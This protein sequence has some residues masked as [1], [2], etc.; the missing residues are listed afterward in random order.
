S[1]APPLAPLTLQEGGP[2]AVGANPQG[3][4][5]GSFYGSAA[6]ALLTANAG[7]TSVS[8]LHGTGGQGFGPPAALAGGVPSVAVGSDRLTNNFSRR[9]LAV[10]SAISNTV[11]VLLSNGDGTFQAPASY[12]VGM[13]PVALVA[14]DLSRDG[15]ADL[16]T[17]NRDSNSVSL[18]IS[19]STGWF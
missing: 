10:A 13:H 2:Y 14:G 18:L 1:S 12:A 6:P 17:A 16:V 7:S 4:A 11:K 5:V 8:L 19:G 3:V 9:D 15:R